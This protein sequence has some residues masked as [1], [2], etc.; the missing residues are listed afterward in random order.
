[1]PQEKKYRGHIQRISKEWLTS[2]IEVFNVKINTDL[3]GDVQ[4]FM[5][6]TGFNLV[7]LAIGVFVAPAAASPITIGAWYVLKKQIAFT[8]TLNP[9]TPNASSSCI[10]TLVTKNTDV[11]LQ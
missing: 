5:R 4:D 2:L 10:K 3:V 8:I 6:T 1:M 7:N 11:L 9:N